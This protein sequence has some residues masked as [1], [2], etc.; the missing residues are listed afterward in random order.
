MALPSIAQIDPR[1]AR[2]FAPET[3]KRRS[4][5]SK[6]KTR[7]TISNPTS[8]ATLTTG[9]GHSIKQFVVHKDFACHYSPVLKAAFNSNFLEGRTQVYHLD[10][11]EEEVGSLLV[12]WLYSQDLVVESIEKEENVPYEAVH[13][14]QLWV[15][16]DKLLIPQLQN[17]VIQKLIKREKILGIIPIDTL[18]DLYKTTSKDSPLRLL[19]LHQ[20]ACLLDPWHFSKFPED[21]PKEMLL[22]LAQF[23]CGDQSNL[24]KRSG[25]HT[26]LDQYMVSDNS[27]G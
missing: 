21:F 20:C 10:D 6:S 4:P 26:N 9:S 5:A 16:A 19:L 24:T 22:E 14:V 8:M 27:E 7:A 1:F 13:L 2:V 12:N 11:V 15:V 17:L 23:A 18:T 25:I 3:S